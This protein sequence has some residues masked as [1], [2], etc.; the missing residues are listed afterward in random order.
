M[1]SFPYRS[2]ACGSGGG[3]AAGST[4][5]VARPERTH[6]TTGKSP[7]TP[8]LRLEGSLAPV[9]GTCQGLIEGSFK[10]LI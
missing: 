5:A 2:S 10:T 6:R 3:G 9:K 7:M 8:A 1:W 4:A